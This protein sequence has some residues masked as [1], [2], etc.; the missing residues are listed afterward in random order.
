[1][2]AGSLE[3]IDFG[4]EREEKGFVLVDI[5]PGP[6]GERRVEWTFQPVRSRPFVTLRIKTLHEDPMV[7]VE[8]EIERRTA[9]LDGAIVRAFIA[10]PPERE[11]LLRIDEVRRMLLQRGAAYVA[12]VVRDV[13]LQVRPRIELRDH[14]TLDP[15]A[16]LEK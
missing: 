7:D 10:V 6:A 8:R 16:A 14:E 15:V 11:E 4:E 2:Y 13:D 9:D 12:K 5:Q 1:V 3:R